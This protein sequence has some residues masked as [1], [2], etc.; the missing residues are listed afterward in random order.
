MAVMGDLQVGHVLVRSEATIPSPKSSL[1][2]QILLDQSKAQ[3][4][5][6]GQ[7]PMFRLVE[8]LL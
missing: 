2:V 8:P 5:S 4:N 6:A 7:Q 1:I 3:G